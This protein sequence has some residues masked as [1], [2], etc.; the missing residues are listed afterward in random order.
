[1]SALLIARGLI[2]ATGKIAVVDTE[3]GT[4]ALYVNRPGIGKFDIAKMSAPFLVKK[5]LSAIDIASERFDCLIIDSLSHAWAGEGGVL[6]RK[7]QLDMKP[8]SNHFTNWAKMTPEQNGLINAV[9]HTKIHLIATMRSKTEYV[10]SKNDKGKDAPQKVGLAPVQRDGFE[11][12]FDICLEMQM[13]HTCTASKD[14]SSLFPEDRIFKPTNKTGEEIAKW[15]AE[16][17]ETKTETMPDKIPE[18]QPEPQY[19]GMDRQPEAELIE[20]P[21][22]YVAKTSFLKGKKLGTIESKVLER[23]SKQSDDQELVS[24]IKA[25]LETRQNQ[26]RA[27]ALSPV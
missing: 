22:D 3:N 21:E 15:L 23:I 13:D 10:V 18:T 16:G 17:G 9:L 19:G 8:G 6:Q 1:M 2:G 4:A 20:G 14:R 11:Y 25:V 12:E 26:E 27:A 24:M 7:E 5:Y